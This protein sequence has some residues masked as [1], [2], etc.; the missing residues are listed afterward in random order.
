MQSGVNYL[1]ST[2]TARR[3]LGCLR[4]TLTGTP[5]SVFKYGTISGTLLGSTIERVL[6]K[7]LAYLQDTQLV[8]VHIAPSFPHEQFVWKRSLLIG[9]ELSR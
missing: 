4:N 5:K 6:T 2:D 1:F 3:S 7:P 8:V 9:D